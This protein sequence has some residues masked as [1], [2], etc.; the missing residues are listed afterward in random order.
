MVLEFDTVDHTHMLEERAADEFTP[1]PATRRSPCALTCPYSCG[2]EITLPGQ[3]WCAMST[4]DRES[5]ATY[6]GSLAFAHIARNAAAYSVAS[7]VRNVPSASFK[8]ISQ[9][10]KRSVEFGSGVVASA[11]MCMSAPNVRMCNAE[12][13]RRPIRAR[14]R[15]TSTAIAGLGEE[16]K[17]PM[18]HKKAAACSCFGHSFMR[19]AYLLID[20]VDVTFRKTCCTS[21]SVERKPIIPLSL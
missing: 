11:G 18:H 12:K 14:S 10:R 1:W 2:R 5:A 6:S 15:P 19:I 20:S 21:A 17:R 16:N 7:S 13:F 8:V 3:S 9:A 4:A